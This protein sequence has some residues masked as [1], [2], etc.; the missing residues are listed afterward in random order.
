M[1][2]AILYL[3]NTGHIIETFS[4]CTVINP[5]AVSINATG[6]KRLILDLRFVNQFVWK[7]KFKLED[8]IVMFEY[9]HNGDFM[10]VC[11]V[12]ITI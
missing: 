12:A 10:F 4:P 11:G 1:R 5:L 3:L 8:W 2:E 7:E 6:K 9:V